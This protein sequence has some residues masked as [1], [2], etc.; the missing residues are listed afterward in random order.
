MGGFPIHLGLG[1]LKTRLTAGIGQFVIELRETLV[2]PKERTWAFEV[3][4][5]T[6]ITAT[7]SGGSQFQGK[8]E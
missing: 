3:Q 1:P 5:A 7:G 6:G 2:S 8:A 4:N